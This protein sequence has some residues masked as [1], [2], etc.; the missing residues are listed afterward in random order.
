MIIPWSIPPLCVIQARLG[1]TR[2]PNKMLLDFGGETLIARAVRLA[3][4]AFGRDHVVVAVPEAD[5]LSPLGDELRR[6]QVHYV[7]C[8]PDPADVL[9]RVYHTVHR[10]R[11]HP[12]AVIVRWTPDDPFKDPEKCRRT[13]HG[14][15]FPVEIGCE[16]FT[17]AML[18]RAQHTTAP[19]DRTPREHLGNHRGLFP[20][21]PLS[22]PVGEGWTI[23]TESDYQAALRRL[24]VEER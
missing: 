7:A 11:W 5:S 6:L 21:E 12:Q 14:E 17:L 2:L 22:C 15:R 19:E 16:A 1:S 8:H 9:G 23:D 18:E 3:I 24:S 20:A 10:F 13:A 4:G